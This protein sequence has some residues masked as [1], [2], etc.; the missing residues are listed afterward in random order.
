[1]LIV[2]RGNAMPDQG[3][4]MVER[5]RHRSQRVSSD[6]MTVRAITQPIEITVVASAWVVDA[7]VSCPRG[8]LRYYTRTQ[9]SDE[10]VTAQHEPQPPLP[11]LT[12]GRR[13]TD[14]HFRL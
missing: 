5:G 12:G 11:M 3:Y 4:V 6:E 13:N 14:R 1:M 9:D 2:L 10:Q 8:T 7:A